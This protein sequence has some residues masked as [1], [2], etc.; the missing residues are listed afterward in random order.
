MIFQKLISL[1]LGVLLALF[2]FMDFVNLPFDAIGVLGDILVYGSWVCGADIII[3][4]LASF[5]FWV[6]VRLSFNLAIWVY[7]HLPFI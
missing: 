1:F 7:E 4:V 5:F 2:D 3:C 6:A